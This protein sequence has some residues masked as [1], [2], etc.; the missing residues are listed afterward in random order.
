MKDLL[1][2]SSQPLQLTDVYSLIGLEGIRALSTAFYNR[3]FD[4][5]EYP[6]FAYMFAS[7][8]DRELS[9]FSQEGFFVQHL[10]G[11][12]MHGGMEKD[13]EFMLAVHSHFK[14][15]P[16]SLRRWMDHMKE[17]LND[18]IPDGKYERSADIRALLNDWFWDFGSQMINCTDRD[19]TA[20]QH[21][22]KEIGK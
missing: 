4:D 6:W 14:V 12:K 19:P 21:E 3:V 2:F 13:L 18:A 15:S 20:P 9:I 11:D 17:A 10:G 16:L 22:W 8:S 1:S 5:K 7:R